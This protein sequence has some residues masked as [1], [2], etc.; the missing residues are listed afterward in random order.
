MDYIPHSESLVFTFG[1][2]RGT[3]F[4]QGLK[5][6]S[7]KCLGI[8]FNIQTRIVY[9]PSMRYRP[10][11]IKHINFHIITMPVYST[12]RVHILYGKGFSKLDCSKIL[13]K[14]SVMA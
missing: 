5:I 3:F 10:Y 2:K 14:I 13:K 1:E 9:P 7:T 4:L 12:V 8:F 11:A 6:S